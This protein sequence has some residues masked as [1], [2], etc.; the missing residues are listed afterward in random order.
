MALTFSAQYIQCIPLRHSFFLPLQYKKGLEWKKAAD[1]WSGMHS[2]EERVHNHW[3]K[4][5]HQ[6]DNHCQMSQSVFVKQQQQHT[7]DNLWEAQSSPDAHRAL[8][9]LSTAT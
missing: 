9:Q 4:T 3:R 2:D 8:S 7:T 5:L 6:H 1:N